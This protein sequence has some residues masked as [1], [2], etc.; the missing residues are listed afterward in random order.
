MHE[1]GVDVG[2][3]F[4]DFVALDESGEVRVFK[5][6]TTP[7]DPSVAVLEGVDLFA[8]RRAAPL[9]EASR[10]VHGTTLVANSLIE[11]RGARVALVTTHGFRD[12]LE[13]AREARYD[14][15]D[16][17]LE[18]PEPLVPRPLRLEVAERVSSTGEVLEPL[19]Q[20]GVD[21]LIEELARLE[22]ESVAVALI[23]AYV[24][25]VHELELAAAIEA[26]LPDVD[27]TLSSRIAA[28][29]REYERTS[30]AAANAFVRPPMRRYLGRLEAGLSALGGADRL[31]VLTS[32]G[33]VT[34]A[35]VAAEFPVHLVESGPAGGVMAAAYF[36]RRLE[37]DDVIAFDMGGT[38]TK[39]S[40]ITGGQPLRVSELEVAR[41]ARFKKGSGLPLMVPSLEL[42]EIGAGGGSLGRAD[43][44]GLLK[45]G[46][47]SAGADPG[48][49]CYARGGS[50]PTVTD[51]DVHL[52]L[53]DPAYF[54]GGEMRLDPAAARTALAELGKRLGIDA[55]GMRARDLR[56]TQRPD[57]ARAADAHRRAR[58][59]PPA[60]SRW[61]R[62]AALGPYMPT[63]LRGGS[64]SAR[65]CARRPP[66][67]RRRSGFSSRP[68]AVDLVRTLPS[69][70]GAVDWARVGSLLD[71]L[72]VEASELLT[73]AGAAEQDIVCERRVEMR[74]AGQ[75]YEVPVALPDDELDAPIEGALRRAFDEAYRARYRF[76]LD[77][78]PVEALHWRVAARVDRP[79]PAISFGASLDGEPVKG[80]RDAFFPELDERSRAT[81]YDRYRLP[82]GVTIDGPAL[83]EERE[84]SIVVGPSG[85]A[86]VDEHGNIRITVK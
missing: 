9:T 14:L 5:Q 12:V 64:A 84:S 10:V 36:G 61:S 35:E 77:S 56:G 59:R 54:L 58:L 70:L 83:I 80:E 7:D 27:V 3:T 74:Y 65:S 72:R 41:V 42:L 78:T 29:W 82:H 51:A 30:T 26:A 13:I 55:G 32:H 43:P 21:L 86:R 45:V 40:V 48:P 25:A 33:G 67:L 2:G 23:N 81:V 49:A 19:E 24:N 17:A 8:T 76:H 53:L 28:E 71:E 1:L 66:E 15:Y 46:P 38:T 62:S 79:D 39:V 37:I 22:V 47:G 31:Q 11:R 50:E 18:R 57:L 69:R 52:G 20:A 16:L 34:S 6:L 68:F 85:S 60:T 73:R 44:L 63:R 75:G 4:T